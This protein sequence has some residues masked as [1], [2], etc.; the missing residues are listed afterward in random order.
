MRT[1][2]HQVWGHAFVSLY[3][4]VYVQVWDY[5]FGSKDDP[6]GFASVELYQLEQMS[7][8]KLVA[9]LLEGGEV[10][11]HVAH[12]AWVGTCADADAFALALAFAPAL[13]PAPVI[14][15]YI[16]VQVHMNIKWTPDQVDT[17][18][19]APAAEVDTA[20]LAGYGVLRVHLRRALGL[21]PP[22]EDRMIDPYIIINCGSS[23]Q[24]KTR[25]AKQT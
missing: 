6:L 11:G 18:A 14:H 7:E 24:E 10:H 15:A 5:D 1:L 25:A 9:R 23:H 12:G 17:R 22:S 8:L 20:R 2:M 16:H 4:Y 3:V 13:A 19:A 21:A